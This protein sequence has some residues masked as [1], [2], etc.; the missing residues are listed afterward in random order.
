MGIAIDKL[1]VIYSDELR[2]VKAHC[3]RQGTE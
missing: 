3:K 2:S 1:T